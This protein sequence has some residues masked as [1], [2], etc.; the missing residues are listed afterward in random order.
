MRV[1]AAASQSCGRTLMSRTPMRAP[2]FEWTFSTRVR[3]RKCYQCPS[4]TSGFLTNLR[5]GVRKPLCSTCFFAAMKQVAPTSA[6]R[7]QP[8]SAE[9][10]EMEQL[11]L[12]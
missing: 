1:P 6:P 11:C 4:M 12:C 7:K 8:G 5:T 2:D 9:R 10:A 3:E